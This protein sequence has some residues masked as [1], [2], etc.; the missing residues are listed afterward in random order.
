MNLNCDIVQDLLPLYEDGVCSPGSRTAVEE[1]L[2][3]CPR[4][5]GEREAAQKLPEQEILPDL[6]E[7]KKTVRS[8]RK[9]RRRWAAS[10]LVMVLL[11]PILILSFNQARGVGLCFTNADEI[12]LAKRFVGYIQT[13]EYDK[14]AQMYDFSGSYQ[15]ILDVLAM[16]PEAPQPDFTACKIGDDIWYMESSLAGEITFGYDTADVW[17]QLIFNRYRGILIPQDQMDALIHR[18]PD[19]VTFENDGYTVDG[20]TYYPLDTPW[21]R[22]MAEQSDLDGFL[23][24][25][26]ELTDYAVH[27]TLMPEEMYEALLPALQEWTRRLLEENQQIYGAVNEMTEDEFCSYMQ[28]K[29]AAE[30]EAVFS[31][32]VTM[33]G[34]H[35]TLSYWVDSF[36]HSTADDMPS[37]WTVG[38]QSVVAY[39]AVTYPIT[40]YPHISDGNVTSLSITCADD[41]PWSDQLIEALFPSYG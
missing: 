11:I 27:F 5:R 9:L 16:T 4:C 22:F 39:Q 21:G 8:F 2:Q 3:T 40:I 37:G 1:H 36:G 23:Q 29:Y 12:L 31:R 24:S 20:R 17:N 14:A 6:S 13:G 7:E 33:K 35:N 32:D 38:I 19:A 25:D 41:M 26:M 15:D 30:L 28:K 18:E 10:L 34:N